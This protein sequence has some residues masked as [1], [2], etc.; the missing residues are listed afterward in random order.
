MSAKI[1]LPWQVACGKFNGGWEERL[2]S[3]NEMFKGF[4]IFFVNNEVSS[5]I[6]V[7]FVESSASFI[8]WKIK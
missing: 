7:I 3:P 8:Q 4:V 2:V 6:L 1:I 5:M